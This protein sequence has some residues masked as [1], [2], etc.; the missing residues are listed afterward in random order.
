M[1]ATGDQ[2]GV[3]AEQLNLGP[4]QDNGGPTQTH[5]LLPGSAAIDSGNSGGVTRDQ[6]GFSRPVG[7]A[8]VVGGDGSDIGAFEVQAPVTA[9]NIPSLDYPA[10]LALTAILFAFARIELRK[11]RNSPRV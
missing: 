2:I 8:K 10:L 7:I 3:T 9:T 6:R 5:A 1:S 4:L 11:R